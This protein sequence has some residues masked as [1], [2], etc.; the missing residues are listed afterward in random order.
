MKKK[1][2]VFCDG[3]WNKPDQQAPT[4]VTK[5]FEAICQDD[6]G[7]VPQI[8]HYVQ[9]VGTR[10]FDRVVGGAFG[11]GISGHIKEGYQFLCSNYEP[12]DEIYLFG[13]SRGAYTARSLAGLIHN[14]GIVKREHLGRINEAY[15]RYRDKSIDWHPNPSKGG[16]AVEFRSLYTHGGEKIKFLGVWDTVGALGSP[17]GILMGYLFDKFFGCRFHGTKL[18]D[19]LLS[20][21][22]ALSKDEHRWPFRPT[23]WEL[24]T[25]QSAADFVEEWFP[26][27]HS[28]V[29]GGYPECGYSDVSLAWMAAQATQR[30]L[31]IQLP[32]V[33]NQ[34]LFHHS[35]TAYY[36]FATLLFVKWPATLLVELPGRIFA[37]WPEAVYAW[38]NDTGFIS[39]PDIRQKISKI[40][41]NGDYQR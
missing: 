28:D 3:T 22:H 31:R 10:W 39:E 40:Q 8:V 19:S 38:L 20:A 23:R 35:Q 1:L 12:G 16:K 14:L 24:Q 6:V 13:F 36:R 41:G 18:S 34:K 33:T 4:N 5:L 29:G 2:V 11:W 30:G 25:G 37:S 27:V 26:G 17:Y 15:E 32:A 21:S 7:G 9:G